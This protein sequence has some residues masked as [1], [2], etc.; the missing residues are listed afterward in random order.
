MN[1][2]ETY[3]KLL[4]KWNRVH[5]LTGA[6][7]AAQIRE[8]IE[9]SIYPK[10]LLEKAHR[11]LDIGSGAGFPGLLLAMEFPQKEF[12]LAEPIKKKAGFLKTAVREL[13]LENTRVFAGRAEELECCFDF[14]V[15]RAVAPT[16][17]LL[18]IAAP[19]TDEQTKYL[20]Y[21][22]EEVYNEIQSLPIEYEIIRNGKRNYLYIKERNA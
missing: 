10:A 11:V 7:S 19:A 4:L 22:G 13:G 17:E 5:N 14:V 6:K 8:N 18:A 12:V 20:F 21:K 1:G 9:D 15:S 2:F 16:K 3:T